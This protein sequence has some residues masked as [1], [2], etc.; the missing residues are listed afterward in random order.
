MSE[1]LY[2]ENYSKK[3]KIGIS[4]SAFDYLV[5]SALNNIPGINESKKQ[6]K[7]NQKIKLNRPI[8]TSISRGILHIAVYIDAEKGSDLQKVT[9]RIHEE[10]ETKILTVTE[11]V[12]FDVQ[13]KVVSLF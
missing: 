11:Q 7:K 9:K 13:V 8:Q 5:S 10:I 6:L 2:I 3:G 4:L 12:P 1:Y